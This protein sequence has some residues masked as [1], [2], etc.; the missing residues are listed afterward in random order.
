MSRAEEYLPKHTAETLPGSLHLHGGAFCFPKPE[1]FAGMEA[2]FAL[3]PRTAAQAFRVYGE[4]LGSA[5][6][7]DS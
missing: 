3:D 1:N 2:G 5:L 4:G 7:R 6:H